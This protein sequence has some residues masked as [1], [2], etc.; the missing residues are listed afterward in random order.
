MAESTAARPS[1]G[2]PP[3]PPAFDSR[4]FHRKDIDSNRDTELIRMDISVPA[5]IFKT[6]EE[7]T[8]DIDFIEF[9]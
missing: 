4:I 8:Q 9:C 3:S 1:V 6:R 7:W 5:G 2:V